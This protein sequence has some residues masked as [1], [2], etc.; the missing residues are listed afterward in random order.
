M[1]SSRLGDPDEGTSLRSPLVALACASFS[2][3]YVVLVLGCSGFCFARGHDCGGDGQVYYLPF[4]LFPF[5]LMTSVI[6]VL[7]LCSRLRSRPQVKGALVAMALLV[8]P[9]AFVVLARHE[10]VQ[11]MVIFLLPVTTPL[12]GG[13]VYLS[14][15]LARKAV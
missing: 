3:V 12:L 14:Y 9:S 5:A 13:A 6:A 8:C 11:T 15:A 7:T 4:F 1:V 2:A 10:I